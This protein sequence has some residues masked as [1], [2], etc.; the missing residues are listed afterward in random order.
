MT[1]CACVCPYMSRLLLSLSLV[2]RSA[3]LCVPDGVLA[4]KDEVVPGNARPAQVRRHC[5][6]REEEEEDERG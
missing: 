4:D 5:R 6:K 1:V 2:L 3:P